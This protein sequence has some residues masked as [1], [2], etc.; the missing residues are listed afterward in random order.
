MSNTVMSGQRTALFAV[1]TI[2]FA[3]A[4][5]P[6]R[7]NAQRGGAPTDLQHVQQAQAAREG[8]QEASQE[9]EATPLMSKPL[10]DFPGKEVWRNTMNA[11]NLCSASGQ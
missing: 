6:A 8:G 4:L 11:Q 7:A 10:P 9:A 2:I 3:A 1:A 5:H